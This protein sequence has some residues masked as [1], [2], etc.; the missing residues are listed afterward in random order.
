MPRTKIS[1]AHKPK[2]RFPANIE[3]I[4]WAGIAVVALLIAAG[5]WFAVQSLRPATPA[6][7]TEPSVKKWSS[8]PAMSIDPS[9]QYFATVKMQK[10]GEFVIQ[11]Y[12][13]KAPLTVNN[14][15]FLVRQH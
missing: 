14:F 1:R 12:P 4:Q 13:D 15:V 9:K 8:P 10:G 11:L 3:P 2:P 5:I 6:A 7:T